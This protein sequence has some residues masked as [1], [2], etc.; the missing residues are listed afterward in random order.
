MEESEVSAAATYAKYLNNYWELISWLLRNSF[1]SCFPKLHKNILG[2]L[3][4]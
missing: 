2:E 4:S 3:F 1:R